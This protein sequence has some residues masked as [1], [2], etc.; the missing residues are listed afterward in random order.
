MGLSFLQAS[1]LGGVLSPNS[2]LPQ[3]ACP[4]PWLSIADSRAPTTLALIR[5]VRPAFAHPFR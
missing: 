5:S 2:G 3:T 4:T 1:V